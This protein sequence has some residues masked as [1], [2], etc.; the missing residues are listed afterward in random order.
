MPRLPAYQSPVDRIQPSDRGIEAQTMAGRRIGHFYNEAGELMASGARAEARAAGDVAQSVDDIGTGVKIASKMAEDYLDRQAI[1][2][3]AAEGE[4][5]FSNLKTLWN[6]TVKETAKRDPN[7]P[8]VAAKFRETVLEPQLEK[9]KEAYSGTPGAQQ[10]ADSYTQRIR[11]HM[12]ETTASD[13]ATLAGV[14]ATN[15]LNT[16]KTTA[17]NTAHTN[18][19]FS[20]AK[21]LLGNV[22][23]QVGAIIDA[24]PNLRGTVAEKLRATLTQDMRESIVKAGVVG[25]IAKSGDP[26]QTAA[27]WIKRYPD[28]L[29]GSDA[30][31]LARA[32]K[33]Q[34]KTNTL[35][36]KQIET[37]QR[38]LDERAAHQAANKVMA[39]NV[40]IDP[41]TNRP[42]IKPEFFTQ[43]L[44]IARLPNAPDGLARTMLNWGEHQ[45]NQKAQPTVS[46]PVV[47]SNLYT[48]LFNQDKPTT[49]QDLM[50]ANI[51]GKLS[52][53]DFSA[54]HQLQKSL[55][56][57][58]LKGPVMHDTLAAVKATL[59]YSMPGIPGRDPKGLENY[60]K[61]MQAFVPEYTRQLRAGT[62]PANALDT[63]DPKSLISQAMAPFKRDMKTLINDRIQEMQSLNLTGAGKEITGIETIPQPPG[64]K[65][66]VPP[67]N[68]QF[69]ASR[70]QYRDPQ[71]NMYDVSGNKVK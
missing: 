58:P 28:L 51:E 30:N 68:W 36:D 59:T 62:L 9:F 37:Y 57:T 43:A 42:V 50:R 44:D 54:L 12:F 6:D 39:D 52:N 19:D 26:E 13:M 48:G 10:W 34:A 18:P 25:A 11:H 45:Q 49:E 4:K 56:E 23:E 41:A 24:S 33:V 63:K 31:T 20:T 32:A 14:A 64:A 15:N 17:S 27:E 47:K 67:N 5:V 7:D 1:S 21:F 66:F 38:Q 60:S 55:D 69:S 61:F 71:G 65:T 8:T 70:N 2:K 46:D 35:Q 22:D 29:S 16:L 53:H 40:S 3:G